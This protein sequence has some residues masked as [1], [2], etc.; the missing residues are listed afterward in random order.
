[1]STWNGVDLDDLTLHEPPPD[2]AALAARRR[3]RGASRPPRP[4]PAMREF[5]PIPDPYTRADADDFVTDLGHEGRFDGTGFGGALVETATG[6]LVGGAGLRLPVARHGRL[7]HRLLRSTRGPRA[8]LRRRGG[9]HPGRAGPSSTG[10]TG[11]RCRRRCA[12][13][14]RSRRAL[15]AGFRFEG[16]QRQR[17]R[18]SAT[19]IDDARPVRPAGQRRRRRRSAPVLPTLPA[20]GLTDGVDRPAGRARREDAPALLEELSDPMTAQLGVRR[21]AP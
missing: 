1:M 13:S 12:T 7:R 4:T 19:S 9:R 18:R 3:R 15:P 11:S 6:R 2:P 14:P 16:I 8:R 21:P 20:D 17:D 10:S 5:L